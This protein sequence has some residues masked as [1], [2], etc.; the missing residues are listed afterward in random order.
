MVNKDVYIIN[1]YVSKTTKAIK[2]YF[3]TSQ[4]ILSGCETLEAFYPPWPCCWSDATAPAGCATLMIMSRC[5]TYC[6]S[7]NFCSGRMLD[8]RTYGIGLEGP[9]P[10]DFVEITEKSPQ[11]AEG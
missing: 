2:T 5:Q 9:N 4:P 6:V 3:L 7:L 10:Q 1:K 11:E 8:L